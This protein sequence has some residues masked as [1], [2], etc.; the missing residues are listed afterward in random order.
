MACLIAIGAV[1]SHVVIGIAQQGFK[2]LIKILVACGPVS[3]DFIA[4]PWA[5]AGQIFFRDAAGISP[6]IFFRSL[7]SDLT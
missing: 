4:C 1:F 6:E 3:P 7:R 5:T 2:T